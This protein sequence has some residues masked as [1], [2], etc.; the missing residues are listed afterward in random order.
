MLSLDT[1][2]RG[3]VSYVKINVYSDKT[4][5]IKQLPISALL[6]GSDKLKILYKDKECTV[7]LG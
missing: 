6:L 7:Y 5:H 1:S 4:Q 3:Y 2:L